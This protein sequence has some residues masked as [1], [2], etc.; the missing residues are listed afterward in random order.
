LRGLGGSK[1]VASRY[2]VNGNYTLTSQTRF[3]GALHAVRAA[4]G[5]DYVDAAS[6]AED[7]REALFFVESAEM[8]A[9]LHRRE[10]VSAVLT[11]SRAMIAKTGGRAVALLPLDWVRW[12]AELEKAAAEI[13]S[14]AKRELGARGL[15]ARI[16]GSASPAA[17]T[18]LRAA[19]WT[20]K[21]GV[22]TGLLVAPAD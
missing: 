16:S 7:E 1:E 10:P 12:T 9:G 15:E 22:V 19:G 11:D 5:A 18:G 17:R 3:I 21:E 6:E 13:A 20:V 8:L 4:G 2:L 14:R